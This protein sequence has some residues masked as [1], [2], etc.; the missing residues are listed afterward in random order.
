MVKQMRG[1]ELLV[2]LQMAERQREASEAR[3]AREARRPAHVHEPVEVHEPAADDGDLIDVEQPAWKDD[4]VLPV[5]RGW[6]YDSSYA[7]RRPERKHAGSVDT[8]PVLQRLIQ[9]FAIRT[10]TS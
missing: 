9:R 10:K 2:P 7:D 1:F 5:L 6:P 8:E 3:L 4:S